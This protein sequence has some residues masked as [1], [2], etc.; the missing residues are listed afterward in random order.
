MD[1]H[2]KRY[3]IGILTAVILIVLSG[4][5]KIS[6]KGGINTVSD[7]TMVLSFITIGKR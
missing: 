4:C 5:E 7:K 6:E 3:K 2:K 1:K